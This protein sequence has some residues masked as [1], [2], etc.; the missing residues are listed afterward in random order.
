MDITLY[1]LELT[2]TLLRV[3]NRA[4]NINIA[5]YEVLFK[6]IFSVMDNAYSISSYF[7]LTSPS[8]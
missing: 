5:I 6:Q 2:K 3:E 7:I 1:V 8:D 4:K